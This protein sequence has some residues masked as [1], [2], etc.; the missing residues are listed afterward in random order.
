MD[1]KELVKRIRNS[2]KAKK[3]RA[4]ITSAM[5]KRG[6]KLEYTEALIK[7]AKRPKKILITS[8]IVSVV[9]ISLLVA[10]FAIFDSTPTLVGGELG[11]T[12]S[13]PLDGFNVMFGEKPITPENILVN[14]SLNEDQEDTEVYLED[15]TI[16]PEFISYLLQE[17]GALEALH[18]NIITR[19][20]P[21]I[22]FKIEDTEYN[23]A[24]KDVLDVSEGLNPEA[25]IQFNSNKESIVKAMLDDDPA[26]V[27][28]N[29][30]IDGTTTI[31][32]I[33]GETELFAKGYLTLY[34]SLK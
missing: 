14:N 25:D 16:T 23:A 12:L 34:D 20:I 4:E 8:A 3:S 9:L 15:I 19:E 11:F 13:N 27:F 6:Y 31:E 33:A 18:K 7:K 29:S 28:K 21:M 32:T 1:D 22:N 26:T 5:M 30:I 24:F 2:F 17:I 10:F